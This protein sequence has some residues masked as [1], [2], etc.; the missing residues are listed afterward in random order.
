M[1]KSVLI[2]LVIAAV[3]ISANAQKWKNDK[4][5]STR[6]YKHANKAKVA[7]EAGMENTEANA[8]ASKDSKIDNY[9]NQSVNFEIKNQNV[10]KAEVPSMPVNYKQQFNAKPTQ[11]S[12]KSGPVASNN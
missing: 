5:Y 7:K 11:K 3:S 9:K 12:E 10:N 2:G 1:K 4:S 6:N 8:Y